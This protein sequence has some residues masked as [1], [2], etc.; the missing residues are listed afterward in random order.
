LWSCKLLCIGRAFRRELFARFFDMTQSVNSSVRAADSTMDI[1]DLDLSMR[2]YNCLRRMRI[3][4]L[5]QI[6]RTSPREFLAIEGFGKK[7]LYEICETLE[8]FYTSLDLQR[9]GSFASIVELWRP[10]FPH[11]ERVPLVSY[12]PS[13]PNQGQP[14]SNSDRVALEPIP[15]FDPTSS[16]QAQMHVEDLPISRRARN[17]LRVARIRTVNDLALISPRRVATIEN[18][19]RRTITELASLL[20]EYFASLPS[21]AAVFYRST[22]ASWLQYATSAASSDQRWLPIFLHPQMHPVVEVIEATFARLGDRRASILAKRMGLSHGQPRKTLEAIGREFHL[23]RERVRQIVDIGLR[24]ILRDIKIHCP[25]VY[26]GIRNLFRTRGVVSLD[27]LTTA[28]PNLGSSV[29][30]DSKACVRLLLFANPCET[31]PLGLGGNVWGSSEI[32]P[33]FHK[34]VLRTARAIL[35]GIPMECAQ[36]SV[37][38]AKS[39][40]QFDDRQIKTIRKLLL[41]SVG[42]LR[43]EPSSKGDILYPPRQSNPD[44][45]RAF[46]YAYIKEQGVPVHIQEIFSA[47]QDSEPEL[48]PD[49]PTRKS[50]ISAIASGLDRDDRFAWAGQSTWGLRE[51][52]YVSRGGSVAAA[53]LEILRA[54]SVPLSTAQIRKEL[55]H[56]YRVS[57][58]GVVAALKASEG[59][60][61]ERNSQGLWRPI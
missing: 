45:R 19:G 21:C 35:N 34:K 12:D 15:S 42:Q 10:Y 16:S 2:A 20:K 32:T 57:S 37:E 4:N 27:D 31:H 6:A 36:V 60:T 54:S 48:I 59:V 22:R 56:L 39:L 18:C 44:L 26:P 14:A 29:Q 30:F 58:A 3:N 55:S 41:N 25:D 53:A 13:S 7:C 61:I 11:P 47:M 38:V 52:G 43:I 28:I 17:V 8:K 1:E 23:T 50:A 33:E 46:V 51:W 49:S 40:R 5:E 9:L 24:L